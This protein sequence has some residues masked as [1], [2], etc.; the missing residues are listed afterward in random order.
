MALNEAQKNNKH[1]S[2][3]SSNLLDALATLE[4]FEKNFKPITIVPFRKN[5]IKYRQKPIH[6]YTN[7]GTQGPRQKYCA[8]F[9]FATFLPFTPGHAMVNDDDALGCVHALGQE[10]PACCFI[11]VSSAVAAAAAS[12]DV[13]A[14][15][16]SQLW[17][18]R[19]VKREWDGGCG[20]CKTAAF[21]L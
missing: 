2:Q 16:R 3:A 4:Q 13:G 18:C 1:V 6:T 14:D 10:R 21:A 17:A 8:A 20:D 15:V 12:G 19:G 5:K 9:F 7:T 11:R